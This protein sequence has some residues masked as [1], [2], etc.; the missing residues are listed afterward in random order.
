MRNDQSLM[1]KSHFLGTKIRNLRKRNHLTMEDLSARCIRVDSSSAPSVSYLSMIERGKR[2]PSAGMLAVIATV[3]QKDVEWFLDD[4]PEEQSITPEK[5]RHG[6][7]SGM[8]LEPSFLF[9]NDILQ[10]AIPEMLS[11][12]GTSGRQFA[13]LLIRAHQEH[14]QNHFP[15]LERAAEDIGKKQLPLA[16]EEMLNIAKSMGLKI[17]W[18]DEIPTEVIDETGASS[19]RLTTSF[20]EPPA[21]IYINKALKANVPRLKYDLAVHIGHCVLHNKDGLKSVMTS[22][23]RVEIDDDSSMQSNTL[24]AQDILHAWRDFE[25]SFFAGALLCPKVPFRQLLDRHGYE[26]AVHKQLQVSASVAMRRMTVVSPYPHWHYFD[27]Y[28]PGKLKAVYRGNG[29][30]LP[31]GNMRI[32]EDPCHHWAVFRKINEPSTDGTSAQ[33]S[34]LNVGNEPRIYC[35]ESIKV[36]DSAGN[37]HVLC[38]GIDLNPAIEAQGKDAKSITADLKK[39]CVD[40]G[41]LVAIPKHIKADLTSVAKILNINWIERG[42]DNDARV[43][44]SRGAVCPRQPSCYAAGKALCEES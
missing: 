22:G 40:N 20:F 33:I 32:V 41:G 13:Q 26:I 6:G 19:A 4:M 38:A 18:I 11:Q 2:V 9:S 12:T 5:G 14:H 25:S 31:W 3:F 43:I 29:I 34:I 30:P 17:K 42:I 24:N 10:I 28:A 16:A 23:R 27:A 8:P 1:R 15:D 36:D 44:C 39:A 7:V 37:P 21:T 35:C